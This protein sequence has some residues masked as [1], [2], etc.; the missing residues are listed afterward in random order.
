[1]DL[2]LDKQR[3]EK[4]TGF[5]VEDRFV[6]ELAEKFESNSKTV[7]RIMGFKDRFFTQEE[8]LKLEPVQKKTE[9]ESK[10]WRIIFKS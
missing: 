10:K 3:G 2:C 5:D 6:I 7:F 9:G 1:M 8:L 4:M